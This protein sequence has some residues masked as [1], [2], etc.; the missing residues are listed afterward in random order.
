M[1]PFGRHE[2]ENETFCGSGC[3]CLVQAP[4]Q[5][6]PDAPVDHKT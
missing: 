3:G 4:H 2:T 6:T 5:Q 1:D